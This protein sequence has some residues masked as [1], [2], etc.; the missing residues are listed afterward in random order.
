MPTW[1][2][3][4]QELAQLQ[5]QMATV[6]PTPGG[7]NAFDVLRRKYLGIHAAHT[8]RATIIYYSGFLDHP[9]FPIS[10]LGVSLQDVSGFMEACSNAD[11][12][13]LDLFL[14]SPGGD[15]DA[16]DQVCAY[17]RPQFDHIRA[18]VPLAAMSAATMMALAADE[19]LMGTHSQLGP[20]DPQLTIG[21]PEGPRTASAQAIRDQFDMAQADC[22]QNP[23]R[24]TAWI[25]ILR[26]YA[27]GLL[28]RCDHAS[29]RATNIVE[30]ALSRYMFHDDPNAASKANATADWFGDATAFLSHGHPVRR[31]EARQHDVVVTDLEDDPVLQDNVLS[32][33]HA[34]LITLTNTPTAKLIENHKG[35]AWV[36]HQGQQLQIAMPM[37]MPRPIPMG[38]PQI[39]PQPPLAGPTTPGGGAPS[40][41]NAPPTPGPPSAPSAPAQT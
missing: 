4:L 6:P 7:P 12:R 33:H 28:A 36:R 29:Q 30:S 25:P 13:Q 22:S 15:A 31:D 3:L 8:G 24:L 20:I 21:M 27:P 38:A 32:V 10:S 19:V 34:T 17:L 2:A 11:E 35:R 23:A 14:H 18:I 41:P 1:G 26:S 5:Q 16:A 39:V 40:A 37:P 9:E